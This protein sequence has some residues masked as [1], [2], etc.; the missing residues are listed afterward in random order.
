M[1]WGYALVWRKEY[2]TRDTDP[3]MARLKFLVDYDLQVTGLGLGQVAAMDEGQREHL[4]RYLS[5][6]DLYI[7]VYVHL[8]YFDPDLDAVRRAVDE[9]LA[10]LD[11][12]RALLRTPLVTTSV[13]AYH[14][15]MRQPSL[16]QQMDRLVDV[17]TPLAH[18]CHDMG[19]PFGI[20]NHG[21]YYCSDLVA[22]CQRVSH[23]GIFLDTGNTYLIGEQPLPAFEVAA[24]YVVG[25][26]FKD[27]HV[28]PNPSILHFEIAGSVI[29]DGDVPMRACYELLAAQAPDPDKLVMELEY[30][31]PKD[32]DPI[33]S[34]EKSLAFVRSLGE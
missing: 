22:L 8:P 7:H 31:P 12:Y 27:H 20:E 26:H 11:A 33:E 25:T 6:N 17:L 32:M 2:L 13:G 14:R 18:G 16:E 23:L 29:G 5:D 15:F 24:P 30:I 10:Q 3:T 21:D 34:L 1:L 19:L 28:Q 4:G 9:E